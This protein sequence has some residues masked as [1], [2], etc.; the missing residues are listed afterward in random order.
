MNHT[1]WLP[2]ILVLAGGLLTASIYLY[3][4]RRAPKSTAVPDSTVDDLERQAQ[5]YVEQLTELKADRSRLSPEQFAAEQARLETLA[6]SALVERDARLENAPAPTASALAVPAGFFGRHPELKGALWGGGVVLFFAVL[7]LLLSQSQRE[8]R[9][10]DTI[11]G[12]RPDG[13]AQNAPPQDDSAFTAVLE[14]VKTQPGNVELAAQVAHQLIRRQRLDEASALTERALG[15]DPFFMENRVHR[16]VLLAASGHLSQASAALE[17]LAKTYPDAEEALLFLAAFHMQNN[18]K[19]SALDD[20]ERFVTEAPPSE[21][22][23]QMQQE[24]ALLRHEL[25]KNK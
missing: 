16:A 9:A 12:K 8:R 24:I 5:L 11:T 2:G 17:H 20:L 19:A 15:Q 14:Q 21:Q 7:G 1:Q 4:S 25:R 6:T 10:G 22:M 13:M 23:P 18:D 3:L